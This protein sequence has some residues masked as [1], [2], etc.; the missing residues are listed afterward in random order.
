MTIIIGQILK[1]RYRIDD[2]LGGG[3]FGAV[4]LA[5][6]LKL[7]GQVAIKESLDASTRA[8]EIYAREA[9]LL[10]KLDHPHL[11]R[12]LDWF[13]LPGEG[14]YLVMR[15]V[16]GE[17]L[18]TLLD[19]RDGRPIAEAQALVWISQV[20][21]ALT[22]LHSLQPPIIHRDIKP[23]NIRIT[24]EGNAV[25]VD[26]GIAKS[27]SVNQLTEAT[28]RAG[29]TGYTPPEQYVRG[30]T[31]VRSDIY[32]LGATLY[33]LLTGA[34]PPDSQL[35][36]LGEAA[37]PPVRTLNTKVSAAVSVAIAKAMQVK[38]ADRYTSVIAFKQALFGFSQAPEELT[39]PRL[40]EEAP[41]KQAPGGRG[42]KVPAVVNR[43]ID[44]RMLAGVAGGLMLVIIVIWLSAGGWNMFFPPKETAVP[45]EVT[46]QSEATVPISAASPPMPTET[47][48]PAPLEVTNQSEATVP[49]SAASPTMP[50][51]TNTPAPR[52]ART[53]DAQGVPMA[54]IPAGK[55]TMGSE[56]GESDEQP[57][58]AVFL[59]AFYMDVYEVTNARYQA[60]VEAGVCQAPVLTSSKTHSDYYGNAQYA[61]YP[62]I[63]VEWQMANTYCAW[64]GA[65]LPTEAEWEKAAR[66][67][68]EGKDY[69]WGDGMDCS[70]ANG[71]NCIGDT[72]EVGSYPANGYGLYDM[73]GNVWEWVAD[74]YADD[75][76]SNK[77]AIFD[78]PLGA[79]S[80][81]YRVLRGGSW[82]DNWSSLRMAFRYG[83]YPGIW[84]IIHVG[85]R[86]G[87]SPTP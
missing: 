87:V 12:V 47:N 65:R 14:Q 32:A 79:Q 52:P 31:D 84:Y 75:F 39:L 9:E 85:F 6:D 7:K 63:Y 29:T 37:A 26:F 30:G 55:F 4:Y 66:G 72:S 22:Y 2:L 5:Y 64:R 50:I 10:F 23:A 33:T 82:L 57:T 53:D 45:M 44:W 19:E 8:E 81:Q 54:L 3:G 1:E 17:D 58:H 77:E 21:D 42:A 56:N 86:C 67:G 16:A 15:Y 24:P 51:E 80:G 49:I 71:E 34:P 25:L 74:W 62:L 28:G 11:P 59:D 69:P 76:Y 13:S 35:I 46:N 60:C 18:Q 38:R 61:N 43:P 40:A 27:Y 83:P 20:C 48:M 41:V 78:N 73:A 68:L 70:K 36:L